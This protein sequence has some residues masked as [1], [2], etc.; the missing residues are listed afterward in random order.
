MPAIAALIASI[1]HKSV[2]GMY[3][4]LHDSYV[5][6]LSS[7]IILYTLFTLS[8]RFPHNYRLYFQHMNILNS[9]LYNTRFSCTLAMQLEVHYNR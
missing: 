5:I 4:D 7:P 6:P 1:D 9:R 8:C 3:E 2:K